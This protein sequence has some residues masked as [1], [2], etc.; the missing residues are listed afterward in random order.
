MT[1]VHVAE[2][3]ARGKAMLQKRPAIS[4]FSGRSQRDEKEGVG[5]I[6]DAAGKRGLVVTAAITSRCAESS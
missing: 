2:T 1:D 6:F 3:R 5:A 4:G